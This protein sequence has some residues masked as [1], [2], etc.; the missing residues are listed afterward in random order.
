MFL[1][2][3]RGDDVILFHFSVLA[4][5]SSGGLFLN[6]I[7]VEC[8]CVCVCIFTITHTFTWTLPVL[9]SVPFSVSSVLKGTLHPKM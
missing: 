5:L 3:S 1:P 6:V 8:V 2:P 9:H 4:Y 7:S